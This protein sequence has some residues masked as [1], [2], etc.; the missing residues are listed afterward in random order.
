[1]QSLFQLQGRKF[2]HPIFLGERDPKVDE[3]SSGSTKRKI[4]KAMVENTGLKSDM[5]THHFI[6][7]TWHLGLKPIS[8][9]KE[10]PS[11]RKI[12]SRRRCQH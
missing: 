10:I 6:R 1:M 3:Q 2:I 7:Q 12:K 8:T 5:M 4:I 9:Y 11:R